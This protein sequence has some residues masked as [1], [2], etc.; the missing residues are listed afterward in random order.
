[1]MPFYI[2]YLFFIKINQLSNKWLND[3]WLTKNCFVDEVINVMTLLLLLLLLLLPLLLVLLSSSLLL[4]LSLLHLLL[5]RWYCWGI[6]ADDASLNRYFRVYTGK[7]WL[8]V[9]T[10]TELKRV[11]SCVLFILADSAMIVQ[12][13]RYRPQSNIYLKYEP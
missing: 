3:K 12:K 6:M 10:V 2:F 11:V 4:L 5:K 8:K 7:I 1:M 13:T 9:K